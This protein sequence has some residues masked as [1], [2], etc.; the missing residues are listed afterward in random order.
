MLDALAAERIEPTEA[1]VR[2]LCGFVALTVTCSRR[3]AQALLDADRPTV[4]YCELELA[5]ETLTLVGFCDERRRELYRALR[6]VGGIGRA[7]ALAVLDCGEELDVLRAVAGK[8]AA[9]FRGVPGLGP[10]R[11]SVIIA[12]LERRYRSS[13]PVPLAGPTRVAVEAR[14]ALINSGWEHDAADRAVCAHI[15]ANDT[16]AERLVDRILSGASIN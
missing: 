13:L 2:L 12:D 15:T 6:R 10:K 11:I 1:G 16:D 7:S 5:D 3:D 4:V 14:D 9:F 8:D